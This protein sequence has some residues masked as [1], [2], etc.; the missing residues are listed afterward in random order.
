M[1]R[2]KSEGYKAL[3]SVLLLDVS[4]YV[5]VCVTSFRGPDWLGAV[6]SVQIVY[7]GQSPGWSLI[8]CTDIVSVYTHQSLAP[9][10]A[11]LT[12]SRPTTS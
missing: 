9:E 8:N 7:T 4:L 6:Y 10:A 5:F 2:V 3:N 12:A 11:P 1:L